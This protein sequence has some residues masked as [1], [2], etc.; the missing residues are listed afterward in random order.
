MRARNRVRWIYWPPGLHFVIC[1]IASLGHIVP[2][3]QFL[4]ILWGPLTI[5]DLPVSLATAALAFS[6]HGVLAG[7][8]ATVVGTLWW[9]FLCRAAQ[10]LAEKSRSADSPPN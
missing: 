3:L 6:R 5:V 7:M 1:L 4:G 2:G 9:Y 8:W 10:F